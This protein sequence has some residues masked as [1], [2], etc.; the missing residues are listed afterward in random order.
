MEGEEGEA[1]RADHG[2]PR[3]QT[4]KPGSVAQPHCCRVP[5]GSRCGRTIP[6][7]PEADLWGQR[8]ITQTLASAPF[9][10]PVTTGR[11]EEQ[12]GL[13]VRQESPAAKE[14][15]MTTAF[16]A[17]R[18]PSAGVCPGSREETGRRGVIV[19]AGLPGVG[20]R[21]KGLCLSPEQP[22]GQEILAFSISSRRCYSICHLQCLR[23][24]TFALRSLTESWAQCCSRVRIPGSHPDS[25]IS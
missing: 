1:G 23:N 20:C 13:R 2:E 15:N 21:G 6:S 18:L 24:R 14:A 7:A 17:A 8:S 25:A 11:T 16:P 4:E 9:S 5:G 22:E 10:P 19:T 3:T 12:V